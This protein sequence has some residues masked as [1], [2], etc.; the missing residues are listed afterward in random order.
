MPGEPTPSAAP[1]DVVPPALDGLL[2]CGDEDK[3]FPAAALAGPG[4]AEGAASPAAAALRRLLESPAPDG[5][6]LPAAGWHVAIEEPA[7]VVFVAWAD[8]RWWLAELVRGEDGAWQDMDLGQCHLAVVLPDGIGFAA[9][10]FDPGGRPA[11]DDTTLRLLATEWACAS[12]RPIGGRLL[13]PFVL[14][15]DDAVTIALRVRTR[16]GGQD[17]PSNPEQAVTVEL[18]APVGERPVFDG[19]SVPP[20]RRD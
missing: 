14:E 17:C 6:P 20:A 15:A 1:T 3:R 18:A 13:Q 9:W 10:R 7:R 4:G 11:A 8:G 19:S 16:P 12:G 5:E 2:T